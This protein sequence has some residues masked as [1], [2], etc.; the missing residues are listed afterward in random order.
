MHEQSHQILADVAPELAR[1]FARALP[2]GCFVVRVQDEWIA[3]STGAT[4]IQT[5]DFSP[6]SDE[7]WVEELCAMT[8]K[9]LAAD[10]SERLPDDTEHARV[11]FVEGAGCVRVWPQ[12]AVLLETILEVVRIDRQQPGESRAP[13]SLL[14]DHL[15]LIE[16]LDPV[17]VRGIKHEVFIE[18]GDEIPGGDKLEVQL[19]VKPEVIQHLRAFGFQLE[20]KTSTWRRGP[21]TVRLPEPTRAIIEIES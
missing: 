13:D 11:A 9:R 14:S 12:Q 1:V 15:H 16:K 19:G 3:N 7:P 20:A 18:I 21:V 8:A 6:E 5:A 10:F 2:D 4:R 17:E